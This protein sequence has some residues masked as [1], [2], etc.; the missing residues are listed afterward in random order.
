MNV[1][2]AVEGT[3]GDIRPALA[4]AGKLANRGH[5]VRACIPEDY[6][7]YYRDLGIEAHPMGITTRDFVRVFGSSLGKP[8]RYLQTMRRIF[9][10]Y[11][12]QQ[13]DTLLAHADGAD[14]ILAS[15]FV[16]AAGT[17]AEKIRRPMAHIIEAPVYLCSSTIPPAGVRFFGLPGFV[18]RGLCN[19]FLRWLDRIALGQVNRR[20]SCLGLHA[21]ASIKEHILAPMV[22]AMDRELAPMPTD[23]QEH[24]FVQ[25]SY[26]WIDDLREL[27]PRLERFLEQGPPPV[28]FTFGSMPDAQRVRTVEMLRRTADRIGCRMVIQQPSKEG[29]PDLGSRLLAVHHVPHARVFPRMAAVVHHGGAGTFHSAARAGVPQVVVPYFFDHYYMA[30]RVAILGFGP[31]PIHRPTLTANRLE[32]AV[33]KVL[34]DP[35]YGIRSRAMADVLKSRD[36]AADVADLLESLVQRGKVG[37]R[38]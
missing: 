12:E 36:G 24:G 13:F 30:H 4:V 33:G 2:I 3:E 17:A 31:K 5:Q 34:Q 35:G 15:G 27:P 26:P 9:V 23:C 22:L 20:R 11:L 19:A 8:L 7:P 25:T 14:V 16:L 1:L 10:P 38:A 6:V 21:L 29:C 28:F 32:K 18:N 37:V